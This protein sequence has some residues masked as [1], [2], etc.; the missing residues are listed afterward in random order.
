MK[1]LHVTSSYRPQDGGPIKR[2]NSLTTF[3]KN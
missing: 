3:I 2:I 1:I